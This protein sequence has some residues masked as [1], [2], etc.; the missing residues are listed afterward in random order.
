MM[1][2]TDM[3][4]AYLD[5][6]QLEQCIRTNQ[7]NNLTSSCDQYNNTGTYLLS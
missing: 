1:L 5:N 7:K 6:R 4:L 3:C 2:N